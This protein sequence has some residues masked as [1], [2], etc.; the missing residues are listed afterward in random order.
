MK[1]GKNQ[2]STILSSI[3]QACTQNPNHVALVYK[4]KTINYSSLNLQSDKLAAFLISKGNKYFLDTPICFCMGQSIEKIIVM[5]AIW[6]AGGAYVSLD[7]SY[8][9]LRLN[10]IL[11]DTA[12][13][14][15]ITTKDLAAKFDFFQGKLI[16][17]DEENTKLAIENTPYS[18]ADQELSYHGLA[19]LAYTSGSTGIPKAVMVEHQGLA[20]F[21]RYF[22]ERLGAHSDDVALNV[23]SSSFDGIVLDLWVP[24][25]LGITVQLY[26]DSRFVG[27]ALLDF[28]CNN[29][30]T[31]LPYL[32][33][34][35]LA[36]LPTDSNIGKLRKIF[37]GGEA[38]SAHVIN[39]WK[40]RVHLINMYGPTETTV[41][42]STFDFS[43]TYPLS[44]IGKP[45]TNV[46]FYVLDDNLNALPNGEVGQL[47]IGGIQVARGYL[48]QPELT[49]ERFKD[50]TS[51]LSGKTDRIYKTGDLV[52]ILPDGN[53]EFIGRADHQI[54]IRGFRVELLDIEQNIKQSELVEN[55]CV[56]VKGD[57]PDNKR[58]ICYYNNK[59]DID[60]KAE[61]L[62]TYLFDLLPSY[63]LPSQFYVINDFPLTPNGKIDRIALSNYEIDGKEESRQSFIAPETE[64]EKQLSEVFSTILSIKS[65]GVNDNFFYFGGNSILAYKLISAIRLKLKISLQISDI[66][67]CPTISDL[68]N[69]IIENKGLTDQD[70]DITSI[71]DISNPIELSAQQ[72]S[73]WFLDQLHGS[74]PYHIGA[75]Y[76]LP[77]E[78][79][80]SRLEQAFLRLIHKHTILRTVIGEKDD[81]TYQYLIDSEGWKL[82]QI[83]YT[84]SNT[85]SEL[86]LLPFDLR[87]DYM[88][89]AYLVAKQG[90]VT[91]LFI[92]IHHIVTD[93]WSMS[94]LI[95]ELNKLYI[96]PDLTEYDNQ[97]QYRD[98]AYWQTNR[99]H[100][101][102]TD[103]AIDFWKVYLQDIPI[104]QL[105][106]SFPKKQVYN[107]IGKQYCFTID[108]QLTNG[109]YKLSEENH[110]TF[111]TVLISAYGMLM[112]YYSGQD[113]FCIG[114]PSAN[115]MPPS[116]NNVMGY[117]VNMLPLR[118]KIEDN[119]TF[120]QCL[121]QVRKMLTAV[122]QH[123][124]LPLEIIVNNVLK[125][126][127]AGYN[128]LFQSVFIL[129]DTIDQTKPTTPVDSSR[130]EWIFNGRAKFDLQFEAIP[131][132]GNL[133]MTIEYVDSLFN[134][135]I[136]I[137]M[138]NYFQTI[139]QLI[140]QNPQKKIGDFAISNKAVERDSV[141]V[142]DVYETETLVGMFEKQVKQR[143]DKTA[144]VMLNKTLTYEQLDNQSS[145]IADQLMAKG[146]KRGEFV[147][148]MFEQSIERVVCLLGIIKAGAAYAPLDTNYPI[149]RIEFLL[150][151]IAPS[152]LIT[153]KQYDNI[154]K[155]IDIPVLFVE[156]MLTPTLSY[157]AKKHR[158]TDTHQP[159]DFIYVIHTSGTTGIPKGV[160]VKHQGVNNFIT[161]YNKLLEIGK[162]DNAMQFS[163][164][165]F[166]GSVI[167]MWIPLV[168][169]ATLY[170][171]PNN[172]LLGDT[173]SDFIAVNTITVIPF[174]SPTVLSTISQSV[175]FPQLKTIGIGGET[176]PTNVSSYWMKHIRL[177]NTYG[178]TET[179]VAVNK[180]IFDEY[181]PANTIGKP[182]RNM[183]FYILDRYM[184]QV[185]IGVTGELY[186][187]G[188]QL[189]EGYL[190]QPKL[191]SEKFIA[192]PFVQ[193]SDK[194]CSIYDRLYKTGDYVKELSDGTLEYIGRKD[195][196]VK[197]RGYRIEI[198]EI[199]IATL[200][201]ENVEAAIIQVVKY[202]DNIVSLRA[203]IVGT[204][205]ISTI[206]S[207]LNKKLP[208]YMV[209][210]EF[211]AI[212]KI[213]MTANGKIDMHE[214][215]LFAE[216]YLKENDTYEEVS[217]NVYEHTI[218]TVWSEVLQCKIR[219][220]DEDFFHMGGHS[221]LLTKL[222]NRLSEH[223]PDKFSL[224]ELYINSS[225]RKFAQLIEG[226][227]QNL[228]TQHYE[229]GNDPLSH[230]IKRDASINSSEFNVNLKCKGNFTNPKAI[231]LTGSTG[232]VGAN[233]LIEFLQTTSAAI[234][235]L[236]RAENEDHAEERLMANLENQLLPIE[237]YNRN[238]NR[239]RF[240]VGDL[241]KSSLGL[242]DNLYNELALE[243][244]VIY[245][246]GSS[247]N[248]IQPY[249][250][251]KAANVDALHTLIKLATTSKLKQISLLSTVGV[252]S[253]EHHFTKPNLIMENTPTLSAFKYLSRDMGYV[254]SKW[255]MEQIALQAIEQG[256]PIIIFRL[257][258]AFCHSVTGATAKYQWWSL[259]VKT[260]VELKSYPTLLN[261][262]EE[263]VSTDFIS[264]SIAYISKNSKAIG[265][266]FH[267]SP[268][269]ENNI[270][271]TEFFEMLR[272][273]FNIELNP[274]PYSDWMKLWE[275]DENSPLYPLLSLFKFKVYDNKSI[276]E[277]HQNTPD[278]DISN[279]MKF[280]EG[281]GLKS[282]KVDTDMLKSYCEYLEI[283]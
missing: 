242:S 235:L 214:L 16:V 224:S 127:I 97:L 37:T 2:P 9:T 143:P 201:V 247:V 44:T 74:L 26:P 86:L 89:R 263:L 221:L 61:Q 257:G 150:K 14:F 23:S 35:I 136:I 107:S 4:K 24:L 75:L 28:I 194:K 27:D 278:F 62:R 239:I 109:I 22:G 152:L 110:T 47:Y 103:K 95:D 169:G 204:A 255:V 32:P 180:Y 144:L 220:L 197:V 244:D 252:Y 265:Q 175:T 276:I 15:L 256:V 102:N 58:L 189:S 216:T 178:P 52:R 82:Q 205:K 135:E 55:C 198:S 234:Y 243:I 230:T 280:L 71:M 85:F 212:K 171:Y 7:P 281:S 172:R 233:M 277:I 267:L 3:N 92:I 254:Q 64:L 146:V 268:H 98:Y 31:I 155:T 138:A 120:I 275:N 70:D 153:T 240:L 210:N 202:E 125:D 147:A 165:N 39:P 207:E 84:D 282:T 271:I 96:Q 65:V 46:T 238:K 274:I 73:L 231:L 29:N 108:K 21:V 90:K 199:E 209:P 13:P 114:T 76:P 195:N 106:Y 279:T 158:Y 190:N 18:K 101:E 41:V 203:Y 181:H 133:R 226:R 245:H 262:R 116:V 131:I 88:I 269:P 139:L 208:P 25:S 134:E 115:R 99:T 173:L 187:S 63:M 157:K 124:D 184:R 51:P 48:N 126:R 161:E 20:N 241:S 91:D 145:M 12:S 45:L 81:N 40:K 42:V 121:Q 213:P 122:F 196:Q 77:E 151:D 200:Q 142:T 227:E 130:I 140:V 273:E 246:A 223:F 119:P 250:Y 188:I 248:F 261:Q 38:P 283:I 8:P 148:C 66:F 78:V 10:H 59:P 72:R 93:G 100:N 232:L 177:I 229:L 168:N 182:I 251:M 141:E 217:S 260:C 225:I 215:S 49:A 54:K 222:Y 183:R 170:L 118:I 36:T 5:L 105:P 80:I 123:Q 160:L 218:K 30:I 11:S 192:N 17:L 272:Q 33:V 1:K 43:D 149:E 79:S 56:I 249:S 57:S 167:D 129:Q 176:C 132:N 193:P 34:S 67:L 219:S 163:P 128:P 87:K 112:Q 174:I 60:T 50:Y 179:T 236:I 117:F 206:K 159:S 253:W 186:L 185:P 113:D 258:Y 266:I 270:S 162:D 137:Q 154:T 164:Y 264:R 94:L 156:D 211:I 53:V 104:L 166:D 69:Y 83:N 19:Y 68:S 111:Y 228:T 6:K 191:T 237:I 259:L